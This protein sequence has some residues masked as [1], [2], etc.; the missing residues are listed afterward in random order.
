MRGVHGSLARFRVNESLLAK[1]EAK[2]RDEGMT[3]SELIRQAVRRE[4]QEAA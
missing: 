4:V 1:A 2:A 3:L